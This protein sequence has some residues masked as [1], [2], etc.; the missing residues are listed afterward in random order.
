MPISD[1]V[2]LLK[3]SFTISCACSVHMS[4][5]YPVIPDISRLTSCSLLPQK[6]QWLLLFAFFPIS[7]I[8]NSLLFLQYII[9][10]TVCFRFGRCHPEVTVGI[11]CHV[12]Y[13]FP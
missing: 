6:L 3:E 1:F 10:H 7:Y 2:E 5:I 11:P 9:H 4:Q 13:R 12:F 8:E